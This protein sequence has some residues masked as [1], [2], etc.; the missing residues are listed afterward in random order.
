MSAQIASMV[1]NASVMAAEFSTFGS[2]LNQKG[3]WAMLWKPKHKEKEPASAH[4][5][6][7]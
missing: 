5:K 3:I 4:P 7:P 2:N 6:K 1:S